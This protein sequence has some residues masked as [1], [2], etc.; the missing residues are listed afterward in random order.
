VRAAPNIFVRPRWESLF[1][2]NEAFDR[3]TDI[4]GDTVE[5]FLRGLVELGVCVF[6]GAEPPDGFRGTKFRALSRTGYICGVSAV[7]ILLRE[8]IVPLLD[9]LRVDGF[10][11]SKFTR[12]DSV[13]REFPHDA[14]GHPKER[15][16]FALPG[17]MMVPH[18]FRGISQAVHRHNALGPGNH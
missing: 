12:S 14:S 17:E 5:K 3:A 2:R 16:I 7:E 15:R 4:V 8:A 9:D 13:F 11:E 10:R 6:F 1:Q 18:S